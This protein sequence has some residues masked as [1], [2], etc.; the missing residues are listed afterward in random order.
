MTPT[1]YWLGVLAVA[2]PAGMTAG[3]GA[4]L[5]AGFRPS[6]RFTHRLLQ[7]GVTTGLLAARRRLHRDAR[8]G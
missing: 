3:L 6:E 5:L 4:T 2:A 8:H 7:A 1:M